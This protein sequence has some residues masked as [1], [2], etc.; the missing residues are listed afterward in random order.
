M[1][2]VTSA[3]PAQLLMYPR[4]ETDVGAFATD[5]KTPALGT[6]PKDTLFTMDRAIRASAPAVDAGI[7]TKMLLSNRGFQIRNYC[8]VDGA[9]SNNNAVGGT[10]ASTSKTAIVPGKHSYMMSVRG[11]ATAT[12]VVTMTGGTAGNG[13]LT[14]SV[15]INADNNIEFTHTLNGKPV[16]QSF[17]VKGA[18]PTLIRVTV[19][20]LAS[21]TT[22]GSSYDGD[23]QL[24]LQKPVRKDCFISRYG[25]PCG[26][27]AVSGFDQQSSNLHSI[28]LN[29]G[30]APKNAPAVFALGLVPIAATIPGFTCSLLVSPM[31]IL[32]TTT[33]GNG[34]ATINLPIN[35]KLN[36]SAYAQAG[37][38]DTAKNSTALTSGLRLDCFD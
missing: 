9:A 37:V 2:G 11:A 5:G 28:N 25:R 38:A 6:K 24:W 18:G 3:V 27:I 30:S 19:E 32:P 21:W 7:E 35:Q 22:S 12:L 23:L 29:I 10:T 15:D 36:F 26:G 34:E 17:S 8:Y 1:L 4:T 16:R 14:A 31:V 33:D 20:G 13:R